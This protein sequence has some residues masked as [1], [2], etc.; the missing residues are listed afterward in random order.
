MPA[1]PQGEAAFAEL[2][3]SFALRRP[4]QRWGRVCSVD[5]Y[6][7][8]N[9][10]REFMGALGRLFDVEQPR[11]DDGRGINHRRVD[12]DDDDGPGPINVGC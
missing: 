10:I 5:Y 11:Y 4:L 6:E 8:L 9:S 2:A 7:N 1:L 12:N 3:C